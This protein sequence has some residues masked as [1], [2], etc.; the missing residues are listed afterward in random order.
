[1]KA[2]EHFQ[3]ASSTPDERWDPVSKAIFPE[4]QPSESF[5]N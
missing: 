1:M 4:V 5:F 3:T 2:E